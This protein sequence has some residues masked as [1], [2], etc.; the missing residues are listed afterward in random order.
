[1]RFTRWVSSFPGSLPAVGSTRSVIRRSVS[2]RTFRKRRSRHGRQRERPGRAPR[3]SPAGPA[4]CRQA[5]EIEEVCG[6]KTDAR[7]RGRARFHR[8]RLVVAAVVS[9]AALLAA[10]APAASASMKDWHRNNYGAEPERLLGG[11]G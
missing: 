2:L 9:L 11:A 8:S 5:R 1:M 3:P 6:V 10:A 7:L 4:C